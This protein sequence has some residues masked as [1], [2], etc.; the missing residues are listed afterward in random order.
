[1]I[2][3]P[4]K[5]TLFPYTPLFR[6]L[7][8]AAARRGARLRAALRAADGGAPADRQRRGRPA[9][10]AGGRDGAG[11][12][13]GGAASRLPAVPDRAP[14][15][16]HAGRLPPARRAHPPPPAAAGGVSGAQPPSSPRAITLS[17]RIGFTPS[18]IGSTSASTTWREMANSSA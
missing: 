2:R 4:P 15:G 8:L 10:H 12:R 3:P 11:G 13:V 18:K 7:P 17:S 6:P 5:S 14:G 9:D 16:R 1:M